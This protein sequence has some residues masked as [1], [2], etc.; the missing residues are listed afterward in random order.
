MDVLGVWRPPARLLRRKWTVKA[1]SPDVCICTVGVWPWLGKWHL[2]PR[3]RPSGTERRRQA[4]G[5]SARGAHFRVPTPT[6]SRDPGAFSAWESPTVF[7]VG[8]LNYLFWPNPVPMNFSSCDQQFITKT[9]GQ[10]LSH[11]KNNPAVKRI[12][13]PNAPDGCQV[14]YFVWFTKVLFVQ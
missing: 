6:H 7:P 4:L 3:G 9:N 11:L 8:S 12:D 13:S 2:C 10:N 14:L 1:R 5:T